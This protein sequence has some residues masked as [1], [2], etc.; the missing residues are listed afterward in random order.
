MIFVSE[1]DLEPFDRLI[2]FSDCDINI[3]ID[4]DIDIF[5][6]LT[7]HPNELKLL[8]EAFGQEKK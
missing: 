8:L 4:I 2:L 3:D 7:L 5:L 6:K 1:K